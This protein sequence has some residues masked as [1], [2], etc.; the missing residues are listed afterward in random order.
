MPKFMASIQQ[1]AVSAMMISFGMM[2]ILFVVLT[3][4][5]LITRSKMP[6]FRKI[7]VN[8]LMAILG[9]HGAKHAS[10]IAEQLRMRKPKSAM[11]VTVRKDISLMQI[12]WFV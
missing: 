12:I 4:L 11:H 3:V 2:T 5:R 8:A 6:V 1:I 7:S 10:L 9:T